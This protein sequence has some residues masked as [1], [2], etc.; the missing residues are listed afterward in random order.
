MVHRD[1]ASVVSRPAQSVVR[2][3]GL[4]A[5]ASFLS[6]SP[7]HAAVSFV[8]D[9]PADTFDRAPGD[10][11]CADDA[12]R[13]T[14]RAAVD[15][16][17]A[18]AGAD[19][20]T[21]PAGS[22]RL[23]ARLWLTDALSLHGAGSS[24]TYLDGGNTTGLLW[25]RAADEGSRAPIVTLTG[26]TVE[27]G[28][29]RSADSGAGLIVNEGAEV[30]CTDCRIRDHVSSVFGGGV[31]NDGTLRL[32]RSEVT[33]NSLPLGTQG[34]L[35]STGGG[36]FNNGQATLQIIQTLIADN[37][38][39]RGGGIGNQGRLE[40]VNATVSGNRAGT[41]GGGIRNVGTGY[42]ILSASTITE[43][44]ANVDQVYGVEPNVGGGL[45][46]QGAGHVEIAGTILA[47]NSDQRS[48]LQSDYAP[49][50]HSSEP[51]SIGSYGGNLIGVLG[52][53]CAMINAAA[54]RPLA[55]RAGSAD[56]ALAPGLAP[57]A[58]VGTGF[59]RVHVPLANS[60]AIDGASVLTASRAFACPETDARGMRRPSDGDGDGFA[61][62]DVGAVE[63][64]GIAPS[65]PPDPVEP[66]PVPSVRAFVLVDT[67]RDR[68]V[69]TLRDG[70]I[71]SR[72]R[73]PRGWTIRVQ[74]APESVGS[75]QLTLDGSA[76][77]ESLAPY[78]VNGDRSGDF[79]PLGLRLGSHEIGARP[80]AGADAT[81][82]AGPVARLRI[83][84]LP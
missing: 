78:A 76:R 58:W 73:L 47:G 44:Q 14:L 4:L 46:N 59:A 70:E 43:N 31:R 79:T 71:L 55:D 12:G 11:V 69:R 75:V 64:E 35:T 65:P 57:L 32:V 15:E 7:A 41:S 82:V 30:T 56:A 18:L 84:L 6:T 40:L 20:I 63:V 60:P 21:L 38:A 26:I 19:V 81:G 67:E 1:P 61:R 49:D 34:G 16:T 54:E 13:C 48:R 27:R 3:L 39:T 17:N 29:T 51:G 45:Y 22:Y 53:S 42:V 68:D 83:V 66:A 2:S 25:V 33:G 8:V 50:C 37:A 23:T 28:R 5:A 80:F 62:C 77:V 74:T 52:A 9:D 36:I 24:F 72:S 10:G